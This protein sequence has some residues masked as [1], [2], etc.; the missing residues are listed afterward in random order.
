MLTVLHNIQR[1]KDSAATNEVITGTGDQLPAEVESKNLHFGANNPL[2]KGHDRYDKH[3]VDRES[4]IRRYAGEGV[5]ADP[6]PGEEE[7]PQDQI[8]DRREARETEAGS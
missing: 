4:D 8:R 6:A 3:T 5:D 1:Y 7:L 2:A